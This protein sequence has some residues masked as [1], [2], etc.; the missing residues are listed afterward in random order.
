MR[1]YSTDHRCNGQTARR[2]ALTV[3]ELTVAV[4]VLAMLLATSM[5]M[6]RVVSDQQRAS[7]RRV[8]ALQTAQIISEQVGNIPWEKLTAETAGQMTIPA[9]IAPYLPGAKVG[10]AVAE[11]T[12]PAAKRIQVETTWNGPSGQQAGPMRLTSWVFP[13]QSP[14]D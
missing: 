13:D 3:I 9:P 6:I 10:I 1:R 4:A 14:P 7:E 11:E 12:E 8:L 2:R 5:K